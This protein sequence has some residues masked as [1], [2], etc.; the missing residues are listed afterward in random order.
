MCV[1]LLYVVVDGKQSNTQEDRD[2]YPM[3]G[4]ETRQIISPSKEIT[5]QSPRP[6]N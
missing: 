4:Q 1:E 2:M 6:T 5:S 3:I